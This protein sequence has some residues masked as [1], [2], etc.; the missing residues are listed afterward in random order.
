MKII[1]GQK[2]YDD[3]L[4][5]ARAGQLSYPIALDISRALELERDYIPLEAGLR[6]LYYVN[7]MVRNTSGTLFENSICKLPVSARK[8]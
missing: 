5:L 4:N 8:K 3:A 1:V 2:I 6:A 7:T